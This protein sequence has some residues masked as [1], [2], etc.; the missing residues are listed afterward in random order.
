MKTVEKRILSAAGSSEK[1]VQFLNILTSLRLFN[2][3]VSR[4]LKW[5][6]TL[7]F[8]YVYVIWKC[9]ISAY[10]DSIENNYYIII[11]ISY[12]TFIAIP[13]VLA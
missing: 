8:T 12:K 11:L 7:W 13:V 10:I 5:L 9:D 3:Q 4:F 1:G 2:I 6:C